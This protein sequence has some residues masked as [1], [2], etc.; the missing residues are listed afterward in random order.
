[1]GR[2]ADTIISEV[3]RLDGVTTAAHRF[4]GTELRYGRFEL[5]HLHGDRQADV[6]LSRALRDEVLEAGLAGPHHI[7]PD[8]GWVTLYLSGPQDAPRAVDLFRR[9][10]ERLASRDRR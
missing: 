6:L 3:T 10:H 2:I 4:G 7:L 8:T 1:M 5:G 9:A